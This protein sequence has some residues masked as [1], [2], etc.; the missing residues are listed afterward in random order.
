MGVIRSYDII[1]INDE[2]LRRIEHLET[3]VEDLQKRNK[4]L[5]NILRDSFIGFKFNSQTQK[6]KFTPIRDIISR[7]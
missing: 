4:K 6:T 7:L 1:R 2:L 3:K 5:E